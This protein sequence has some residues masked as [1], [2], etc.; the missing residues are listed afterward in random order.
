MYLTPKCKT[1]KKNEEVEVVDYTDK[2]VKITN[3]IDTMDIKYDINSFHRT[4]LLGY[5]TT[6]HK[7]QGDTID[8][9]VNVFDVKFIMEWL[10]DKRALYTGLSRARSLSNIRVSK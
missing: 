2:V 3:G 10:D 5:A 7:S 1:F 4:F 9:K 8:G 6:I